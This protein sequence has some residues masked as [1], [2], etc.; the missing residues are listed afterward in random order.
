[1]ELKLEEILGRLKFLAKQ[2]DLLGLK[3]SS[4]GEKPSP[5]RPTTSLVEESA[6]YGREGDSEAITEL[7]SSVSALSGQ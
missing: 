3:E 7:R 2:R 5:K 4:G 6:V 1:M